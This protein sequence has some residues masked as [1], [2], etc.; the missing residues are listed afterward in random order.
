MDGSKMIKITEV[1]QINILK[2]MVGYFPNFIPEEFQKAKI[3]FLDML[4]NET[5]EDLLSFISLKLEDKELI[6]GPLHR[7][8]E[9]DGVKPV[10]ALVHSG[11]FNYDFFNKS[12]DIVWIG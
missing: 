4:F 8:R 3:K 11:N 5:T 9:F 2:N 7:V 6:I 1:I 12:F 10:A